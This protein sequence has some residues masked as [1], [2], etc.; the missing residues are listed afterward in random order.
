MAR[1]NFTSRN[2][3]IRWVIAL[4]LVLGT[5]NPDY[6][7]FHWV[8]NSPDN[9]PLKVFVGIV[10]LI[11]YVIYLRATF[12]SIGPI[13]LVLAGA[14]FAALVWVLVDAGEWLARF[15]YVSPVADC[16]MAGT[17]LAAAVGLLRRR[18]WGPIAGLLSAGACVFIGITAFHFNL[19]IGAFASA[20]SW[21]LVE[22]A[23]PSLLLLLGGVALAL[24]PSHLR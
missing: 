10:I 6:S 2:F 8:T 11:V 12:R 15:P 13:G 20:D 23:V 14:F 9:V 19:R 24:L 4:V 17:G 18:R 16:W 5:F 1:P 3:M 21:Q 22:T 7:F